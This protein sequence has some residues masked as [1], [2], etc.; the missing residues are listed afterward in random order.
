MAPV[1]EEVAQEDHLEDLKPPRLRSNRVAERGWDDLVEP[2][3][4]GEEDRED[5]AIPQKELAEKERQVEPPRGAKERLI[6]LRRKDNFQR[7]EDEDV[8]SEG[9]AEREAD[10]KSDRERVHERSGIRVGRWAK[11]A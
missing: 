7:P 1:D 2:V 4:E 10:R 8:Q 11:W 5:Q 6:W 9:E 3:A